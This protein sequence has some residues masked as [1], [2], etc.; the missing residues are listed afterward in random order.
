M[1][2]TLA[3]ALSKTEIAVL[4]SIVQ[5][6]DSAY[7]DLMES[8][9][10]MFGHP[11]FAD[12]RGRIRTK[13]VQIQCEIESHDP[14]F[15]FNFSQIEFSYM[16]CIPELRTK[17]IIIHIARTATLGSLP[18]CSKYKM[19]LSHNNTPLLRQFIMDFDKKPPISFDP[20]Y[21]ILAFGGKEQTFSTIQFPE[22]GFS[23]IAESIL[24]PQVIINA[25]SEESENFERKKS[26]LKK[27]FLSHEMEE[28]V[29]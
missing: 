13:L 27:E 28:V 10:P 7:K 20:F 12:M 19:D 9:R 14:R 25:E 21:G 3:N 16:H 11:Y 8:Q 18:Y 24:I 17:N 4:S 1:I 22:P 15:P 5:V 2:E 23:G 26:K 6:G 29:I